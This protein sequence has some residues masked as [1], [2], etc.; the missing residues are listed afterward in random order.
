MFRIVKSDNLCQTFV[1]T[2]QKS[3][4]IHWV[5]TED[6]AATWTD[7][8]REGMFLVHNSNT[9]RMCMKDANERHCN[10]YLYLRCCTAIVF[11]MSEE[12]DSI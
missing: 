9:E 10:R 6:C 1:V 11:Q 2:S 5:Y 7:K 4:V 3:T 8:E 12:Q